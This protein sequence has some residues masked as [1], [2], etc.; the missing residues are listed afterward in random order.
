M[1]IFYALFLSMLNQN[2]E[3]SLV[4]LRNFISQYMSQFL[5]ICCI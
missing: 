2:Y 3:Q 5:R 1:T 4:H